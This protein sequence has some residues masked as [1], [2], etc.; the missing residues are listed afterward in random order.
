MIKVKN[1]SYTYKN[2]N[3]KAVD[4]ISFDLKKGEIFGFLGPSGAGKSTTQKILIK[5]LDQY[6][7][8][9]CIF[10]KDLNDLTHTFYESVGIGFELPNNYTKL[11][12]VE[13]LNF[14]KSF[15]EKSDV[16]IDDLLKSVGLYEQRNDKVEN[17][18]KGMQVRLNFIRALLNDADLLFFDEPTTGLDPVNSKIIQDIILKEKQKG[19]TIFIT[20]HSMQVAD[21]LCDTIA[22][23]VDG[24]IV[25]T[26]TPKNLK[27]KYG[28][29]NL[30]VEYL[31]ESDNNLKKE[32]S[33][34]T[35]GTNE[36]FLNIIKTYKIK[37]IHS[38][39]TT[40]E[41]VF[42]KVTGRSLI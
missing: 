36:E 5:L 24:K 23:I 41:D 28:Q 7:G 15:Y 1:L 33:L 8:S 6:A 17:F 14:F 22:F 16:N 27:L 29:R 32:Y 11:T 12:A 21:N 4:D 18:S 20:T 38:Q 39:E 19:K 42:I 37:T 35:F 26:D 34:D 3:T 10:D 2:S 25:E 13:N 40:L 9:V 30:I 31:D